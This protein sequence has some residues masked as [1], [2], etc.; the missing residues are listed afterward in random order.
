M[1]VIVLFATILNYVVHLRQLVLYDR[2]LNSVV[3]PPHHFVIGGIEPPLIVYKATHHPVIATRKLNFYVVRFFT[4]ATC[5]F[6][7]VMTTPPAHQVPSLW[8]SV[9]LFIIT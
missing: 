8:T 5:Y 3:P 7:S 6:P 1:P 9:A 2:E 4:G